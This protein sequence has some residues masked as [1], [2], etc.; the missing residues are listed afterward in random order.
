M[1]IQKYDQS[2][3]IL[4][5][6]LNNELFQGSDL[7]YQKIVG[8]FKSSIQIPAT[9]GCSKIANYNSIWV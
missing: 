5:F 4:A 7:G 9:E 1:Q 8:H 6:Q 3:A 2:A